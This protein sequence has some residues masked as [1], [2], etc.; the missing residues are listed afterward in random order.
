MTPSDGA[1]PVRILA[2]PWLSDH[3]VGDVQG[4]FPRLRFELESLKPLHGVFVSHAHTDHLDPYSLIRLWR[5]LDPRPAL[6]LPESLRFLGALLREFLQDVEIVFLADRQAISFHGLSVSGFFNPETAPTN[7]DDV[8][9]FVARN[10]REVF[11]SESDAVFPFYHPEGR[12][13]I[14]SLF[15]GRPAETICYLTTKNEGDA[16]MSMLAA[17]DGEDRMRRLDQSVER[18]YDEIQQMYTPV[19]EGVDDLWQDTRLVRLV[20]GQGICYPQQLDTEWNRVLFPIRLSDRVRMER[21]IAEQCGCLHQIEE[22]IPG[23]IHRVLSGGE[24]E[25]RSWESVEPLDNEAEREF[26]PQVEVFEDFPTAPLHDEQRDR[27]EQR[28]RI[29]EC[30]NERFLPHLIGSRDPPVEH[31]LA[32]Q[33]GEHRVRCRFGTTESFEEV[34]FRIT[35]ERLKFEVV[36]AGRDA[37]ETY[38]ANDL[39]DFFDG[40][41]D[42]FSTI[43]RH[44][45]PSI[46]ERFWRCL[47]LPYLNNDFVEKKLRLHFE[48]ALNGESSESWVLN[49][50]R[51]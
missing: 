18:T 47:G 4:R 5:E 3:V 23:A 22:L 1:E 19:D 12:D 17:R 31:L 26:D 45:L 37:H 14:A 33:A 15:E 50:Y 43:C 28:R 46:I 25:R 34:D 48:R 13:F 24:V 38:W 49:F 51:P 27:D 10:D 36:P 6:L 44:P 29:L 35:F 41:C 42:E 7:E 20:G 9:A 32:A 2:D 8:M 39:E 40:R 30:L 11:L 21:E 16:T